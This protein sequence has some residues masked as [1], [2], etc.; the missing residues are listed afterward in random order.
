LTQSH[1]L[2]RLELG[3]RP[4]LALDALP[5]GFAGL[6]AQDPETRIAPAQSAYI[7]YT[8]GTTG[9]PKGVVASYANLG[10]Y[11]RVA[12]ERYGLASSDVMPALARF[13]FSISLFEL[14]TP[15]TAGGKL[16]ILEREHVLDAA[17]LARTLEQ[18]TIFHAG[19][20]LL[21]G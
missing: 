14:L 18:V 9:G 3:E 5:P 16:L 21:K 17:R 4:A 19:P 1:L 12:C 20:S 7:F 15:L 10:H 13:S 6:S 11:V 8:S 2:P